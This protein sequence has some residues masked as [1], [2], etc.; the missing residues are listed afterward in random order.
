MKRR[1]ESTAHRYAVPVRTRA[2]RTITRPD[3]TAVGYY[4]VTGGYA[5]LG[6]PVPAPHSIVAAAHTMTGARG[7]G[8]RRPA[9]GKWQSEAFALFREVGEL[10]YSGERVARAAS[11]ARLMIAKRPTDTDGEPEP[12]EDPTLAALSRDMF[13]DGPHTAQS[14]RRYVQH[15]IFN[16]ESNI[17]VSD[18]DPDEGLTFRPYSVKEITGKSGDWKINDGS[19]TPRDVDEETEIL[20]RSWT[21]DPEVF[22]WADCPVRSVLPVARELRG[23]GQHVSA[24]IDSRLAGA[25]MLV[26]PE[27]ISLIPGQRPPRVDENGD[28]I[29]GDTGEDAEDTNFYTA[30]LEAMMTA[31][32]DRDDASAIVPLMVKVRDDLVGKVQHI[33]F[34]Q[35]FDAQAKDL[36]DEAIRRVALGMDSEPETL[37]GMSGANHWTGFLVDQNEV[38]L[39][40]A[41]MVATLCHSLTNSWLRPYLEA[42]AAEGQ[43]ADDPADYLVWFDVSPLELR[44][45]RSKDAQ[46]LHQAG[47]VSAETLRRE[48]GFGDDDAPTDEEKR[49]RILT[50]LL[51]ARPDLANQLLPALGI[52]DVQLTVPGAPGG[53]AGA[54]PGPGTAEPEPGPLPGGDPNP[55]APAPADRTMPEQQP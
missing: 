53:A 12:V 2:T 28:P 50:Q 38:R 5:D 55:A 14:I 11:L 21:P 1:P 35:P 47:A 10:R 3:G 36:R 52:T 48:S 24:Q 37:L 16:G 29:D 39:V 27:S 32:G 8:Y 7:E 34:A 26:V 46:A 44:P 15:M 41:P 9:A 31:I 30:L 45:D 13:G 40:I 49:E 22:Q 23:L 4:S 6:D 18:R 25:G 17:L 19:G 54:P 42:L 33:S 51:T 43:F 20:I